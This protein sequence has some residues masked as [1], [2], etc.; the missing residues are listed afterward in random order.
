MS[1][2][3]VVAVAEGGIVGLL[4]AP[5]L[6]GTSL[7]THALHVPKHVTIKLPV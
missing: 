3:V 7:E 5:V 2:R 4:G 1:G 6:R